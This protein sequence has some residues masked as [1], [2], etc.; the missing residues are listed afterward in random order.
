L[1]WQLRTSLIN[2]DKPRIPDNAMF[3]PHHNTSKNPPP[4]PPPPPNKVP[5]S[6]SSTPWSSSFYEMPL[7]LLLHRRRYC[8]HHLP[9]LRSPQLDGEI[10][11]NKIRAGTAEDGQE[12]PT[13]IT[14][15][16]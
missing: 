14:A 1:F 15:P 16:I 13:V 10:G 9:T 6:S 4:P 7:L 2:T 11:R 5:P 8:P 12:D 3:P